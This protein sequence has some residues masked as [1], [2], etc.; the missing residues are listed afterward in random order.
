MPSNQVDPTKITITGTT[1][2]PT[3]ITKQYSIPSGDAQIGTVYRVTAWGDVVTAGSP[4]SPQFWL[5]AFGTTL[6]TAVFSNVTASVTYE[7][8][9]TGLVQLTAIGGSG[10]AN[11][12]L[13][14]TMNVF[15]GAAGS[16][17]QTTGFAIAGAA[18]GTAVATNTSSV[19]GLEFDFRGSNSTQSSHSWGSMLERIGP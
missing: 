5:T 15:T 11:A 3:F 2:T 14:G 10:V 6:C 4:Q 1:I 18:S 17:N 13:T 8:V 9:V 19:L 16:I 7:W 12:W